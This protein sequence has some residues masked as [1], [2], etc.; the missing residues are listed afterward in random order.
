MDRTIT[1]RQWRVLDFL[2]QDGHYLRYTSLGYR[3]L[4]PDKDKRLFNPKTITVESMIDRGLIVRRNGDWVISNE[5][6]TLLAAANE[7]KVRVRD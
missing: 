4:W 7:G 3:S 2:A 5:G 1:Q 6:R